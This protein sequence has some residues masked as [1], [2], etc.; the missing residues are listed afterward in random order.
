MSGLA[1]LSKTETEESHGTD[2][3]PAEWGAERVLCLPGMG[4]LDEA[5]SLIVAQVLRKRGF[6]V[7]AEQADALSVSR[8]FALDTS[9]ISVI[10][11]CYI[12]NASAAQIGYAVRRLRRKVP[13]AFILI[14]LLAGHEVLADK[15][16]LRQASH[17]DAIETSLEGVRDCLA[18]H[19]EREKTPAEQNRE[20][21]PRSTAV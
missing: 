4:H 15:E 2:A 19:A 16:Q 1:Q 3:V 14:A 9:G 12:E 10:C 21:A 8:I 6:G 18:G 7:R 5:V 20:V 13:D 17:A 11:F